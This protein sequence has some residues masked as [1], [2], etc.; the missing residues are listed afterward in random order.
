MWLEPSA[1]SQTKPTL[2]FLGPGYMQTRKRGKVQLDGRPL[3]FTDAEI[4][5]AT[6]ENLVTV[7][8]GVG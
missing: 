1:D 3:F 5:L 2:A 8:T 6:C 4:F 7:T